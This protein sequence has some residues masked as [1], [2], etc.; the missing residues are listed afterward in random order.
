MMDILLSN[1]IGE[2]EKRKILQD[3]YDIEITRTME[4]EVSDTDNL[5]EGIMEKGMAKGIIRAI[6]NLMETM[7]L[8]S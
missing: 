7:D 8:W 5:C 3:N 1:E 4:K 2:A 6:K